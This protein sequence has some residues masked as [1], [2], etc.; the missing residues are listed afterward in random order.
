MAVEVA[1]VVERMMSAGQSW[2]SAL[3]AHALAPPDAG[4]PGR[5][6]ALSGAAAEQADAFELAAEG[7]LGWRSR[8][9]EGEFALAPE[10]T[11][12]M[13]RP[14]PR[15]CGSAS[16]SRPPDW[17]ARC[18]ERRRPRSLP[19]FASCPMSPGCLPPSSSVR[20]AQPAPPDSPMRIV[21]RL[22]LGWRLIRLLRPLLAAG[23]LAGV[24][25]D[26]HGH[27]VQLDRPTVKALQ[28]GAATLQVFPRLASH[29]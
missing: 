16:T 3:D 11:P 4:F 21:F 6:R 20:T 26:F 2:E 5:L 28:G 17:L 9:I 27:R 14:G 19:R 8:T 24:L 13:T 7:G 29:T 1:K 12:G 25:L 18:R 15:S 10:L 22:Y 23:V